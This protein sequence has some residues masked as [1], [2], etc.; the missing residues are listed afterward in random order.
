[1]GRAKSTPHIEAQLGQF[2]LLNKVGEGRF[3]KI[4][5]DLAGDE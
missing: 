3:A 5:Y 4:S 1:L 2:P